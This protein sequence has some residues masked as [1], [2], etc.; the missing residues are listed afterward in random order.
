M[1]G[2][3]IIIHN[4]YIVKIKI[5]NL[6]HEYRVSNVNFIATNIRCYS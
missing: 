3:S 1:D 4:K 2:Y 6:F 5:T